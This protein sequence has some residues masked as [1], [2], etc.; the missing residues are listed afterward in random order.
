MRHLAFASSFL[1]MY[2]FIFATY[3]TDPGAALPLTRIAPPV[4]PPLSPLTRPL[5]VASRPPLTLPTRAHREAA[6]GPPRPTSPPAP[7]SRRRRQ[8]RHVG[9][10]KR[11]V[12]AHPSPDADGRHCTRLPPAS[13]SLPVGA[14]SS[15]RRTAGSRRR[16]RSARSATLA[17]SRARC[18]PSTAAS[19][20]GASP[21]STTTARTCTTPSARATTPSSSHSC[22]A[23]WSPS[24][25]TRRSASSTSC[26][27][28]ATAGCGSPPLPP[29]ARA[30]LPRRE[31][32]PPTRAPPLRKGLAQLCDHLLFFI[33]DSLIN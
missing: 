3:M 6:S 22:F 28:A 14:P 9:R 15:S 13:S 30:R 20:S 31:A 11:P 5:P 29:S 7:P 33:K 26:E 19:S 4:S 24:R 23:A 17:T 1:G 2:L 16:P 25:S 32:H 18:A 27:S 21:P 10:R 12:P 8:H